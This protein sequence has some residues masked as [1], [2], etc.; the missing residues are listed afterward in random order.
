MAKITLDTILSS[1]ASTSLFNTNFQAIEDEMNDKIL[2]RD[3]PMGE[4]NEMLNDLD[5]NSNDILNIG[6]T[7]TDQLFVGGV[8]AVSAAGV[9]PKTFTE[10]EFTNVAGQDTF[11]VMYDPG[12]LMISINGVELA[13]ADYS[14]MDGTT[15]VLTT[16]VVSANDIVM[17]RAFQAFIVGNAMQ[18]NN[19]LSDVVSIPV[20]RTNLDVYSKSETEALIPGNR[21]EI[22][23]GDLS[24]W[25]RGTSATIVGY[26]TVDRFYN[27][28]SQN[29]ATWSQQAFALGQTEVEGNP[30][31]YLRSFM[32]GVAA[33]TSNFILLAHRIEDVT[34]TSGKEVTLSFYA[35]TDASQNIA[36]E[37]VQ[38]FG[39][40]GSPSTTVDSI[41]VTTVPT[42]TAW[43]RYTVTATIPSVA[44]KT[45]GTDGNDYLEIN[46][47][48][49]AGSDFNSR[50]NSIG[51]NGDATGSFD[52]AQFQLEF[53]DSATA[54]EFVKP[55]DQLARCQ[56]Y[57]ERLSGDG[58]EYPLS[59]SF[60]DSTTT[61]YVVFNYVTKRVKPT[62]S[63]A[64]DAQGIDTSIVVT[65][66]SLAGTLDAQLSAGRCLWTRGSGTHVVGDL[67]L[68]R[69][70]GATA[71]IDI[72]AEL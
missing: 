63:Y 9:I 2:Y 16:P 5:M 59:T 48:Q 55:A 7:N 64:G 20:S 37:F 51:V 65:S 25:Q 57:F 27:N 17:F 49:R 12:F 44:G 56:R 58:D 8:E 67:F 62:I 22:I 23:N 3:N 24:V 40:G 46:L 39:T 28:W 4:A 34:K 36:V 31:Y 53:G 38:N 21:N 61:A 52:L 47:W 68:T 41:S 32:N 15:V 50:T 54:V 60:A 70:N 6:V 71:T 26:Q 1:F 14:A 35:K 45:L 30:D 42:T 13:Q 66:G 43:A 18:T 29:S 11:N 69:L 10:T 33:S 72:D 19:N